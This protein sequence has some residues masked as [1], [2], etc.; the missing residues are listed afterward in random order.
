M[1]PI[2]KKKVISKAKEISQAL[3][4]IADNMKTLVGCHAIEIDDANEYLEF[5][6]H[7]FYFW[8]LSR[9]PLSD[10]DELLKEL[11]EGDF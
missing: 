11:M 7:S 10:I 8:L 6:C 1:N 9:L 2:R 5:L 3:D 4:T